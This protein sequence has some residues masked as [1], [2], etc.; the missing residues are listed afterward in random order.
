LKQIR[1][2]YEEENLLESLVEEIDQDKDLG[3]E[4]HRA[5]FIADQTADPEYFDLVKGDEMLVDDETRNRLAEFDAVIENDFRRH[6][7]RDRIREVLTQ[8]AETE[9]A[10]PD[11]VYS[12][13][14][15]ETAFRQENEELLR[16]LL[17]HMNYFTSYSGLFNIHNPIRFKMIQRVLQSLRPLS[18]LS[19]I[20]NSSLPYTLRFAFEIEECNR[21]LAQ[22]WFAAHRGDTNKNIYQEII[23]AIND[24]FLLGKIQKCPAI[25]QAITQALLEIPEKYRKD[26]KE[27]RVFRNS[28]LYLDVLEPEEIESL[29][30]QPNQRPEIIEKLLTDWQVDRVGLLRELMEDDNW[31]AFKQILMALKYVSRKEEYNENFQRQLY[32]LYSDFLAGRLRRKRKQIHIWGPLSKWAAGEYNMETHFLEIF[33]R[34]Y[35]LRALKKSLSDSQF[36]VHFLEDLINSATFQELSDEQVLRMIEDLRLE[37]PDKAEQFHELVFNK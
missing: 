8:L 28:P 25:S 16:Y 20:K 13:E 37:N 11:L 36:P 10:L 32:E 22:A 26:I 5:V 31:P 18:R 14:I 7:T 24:S 4:L 1:R 27:W 23:L 34:K 29:L 30:I 33:R 12:D 2:A 3:R 35:L 21:D 6:W 17:L 15:L 19:A 9:I